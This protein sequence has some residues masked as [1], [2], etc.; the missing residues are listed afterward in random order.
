MIPRNDDASSVVG[1]MFCRCAVASAAAVALE[2]STVTLTITLPAVIEI[3]IAEVGTPSS[4]PNM[5]SRAETAVE[6]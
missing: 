1:M 4:S 2:A 5:V 3:V 6:S